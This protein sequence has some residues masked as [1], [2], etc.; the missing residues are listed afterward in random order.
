[1]EFL[2]FYKQWFLIIFRGWKLIFKEIIGDI[3]WIIKSFHFSYWILLFSSMILFVLVILPWF[4]Y[5]FQLNELETVYLRTKKWYFF[6]IPAITPF[7][8][9][10]IYHR[11]IYNIQMFINIIIIT[12]YVYGFFNKEFHI[13]I[14]GDYHTSFFYYFYFLGLIFHTYA[15]YALK[16]KENYLFTQLAEL[17]KTKI[18]NSQ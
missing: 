3:L 7:F 18:K 13:L 17:W 8:F 2:L 9:A 12:L 11:R 5:Q 10:F 1:M 6:V 15:I 16:R 14:K 4:S